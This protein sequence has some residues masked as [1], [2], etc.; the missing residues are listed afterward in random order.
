MAQAQALALDGTVNM[1]SKFAVKGV[2]ILAFVAEAFD[3]VDILFPMCDAP[4]LAS[5][6]NSSM[7]CFFCIFLFVKYPANSE[8]IHGFIRR[9]DAFGDGEPMAGDEPGDVT[10][11]GVL[12][13]EKAFTEEG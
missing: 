6:E 9:R 2:V 8:I 13:Q 4:G 10:W 1:D 12:A 11:D 3:R 5:L 7:N